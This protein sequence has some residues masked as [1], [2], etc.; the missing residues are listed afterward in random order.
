MKAFALA[1]FAASTEAMMVTTVAKTTASLVT[2]FTELTSAT[3]EWGY[4]ATNI[5]VNV[6]TVSVIGAAAAQDTDKWQV[7]LLVPFHAA[8]HWVIGC[9]ISWNNSAST[10]TPTWLFM[11]PGAPIDLSGGAAKVY[12]DG[13]NLGT[14]KFARGGSA[15]A[16]NG[17]NAMTTDAAD[18]TNTTY[19]ILKGSS[20]KLDTAKT[21]LT[22]RTNAKL[23]GVADLAT[24]AA[25]NTLIDTG[26]AASSSVK[27]FFGSTTTGSST[28]EAKF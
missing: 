21:G 1:L 25:I 7:G 13:D 26:L 18:G 27:V 10:F 8:N 2:A 12:T 14:A 3:I 6:E 28:I 24:A 4:D 20:A 23:S 9:A 15:T 19:H 16:A 11:D 5:Y 17:V 22:C